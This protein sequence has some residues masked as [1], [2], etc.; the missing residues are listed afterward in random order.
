MVASLIVFVST[1]FAPPALALIDPGQQR[2]FIN[3]LQWYTFKD[4][5]ITNAACNNAGGGGTVNLNIGKDFTLGP[6]NDA[7]GRQVALMKAL[8]R[9]YGLTPTQAAGILGNFMWESGGVNIPPNVNEGPKP[10]PPL[11]KGGYGWA[12]WT[13]SRQRT[14]IRFAT[15]NGYMANSFVDATDA[16][17]YA[18]L[19]NELATG[20]K[21]TIPQLKKTTTTDDAVRSFE[22]TYESAGTPAIVERQTRAKDALAAFGGGGS[23]TTAATAPTTGTGGGG[24]CTVPVGDANCA[25]S[26]GCAQLLIDLKGQG[27]VIFQP[28]G[29]ADL[30]KTAGGKP[31]TNCGGSITLNLTLLRLLIRLANGLQAKSPNLKL[32]IH[33]FV[34]QHEC[35]SGRHPPGR[36]SDV[37]IAG[38]PGDTGLHLDTKADYQLPENKAFAQTVMDNLP[39]P[40]PANNNGGLGQKQFIGQLNNTANKRYFNDP[41]DPNAPGARHFHIDVG[42]LAP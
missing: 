37:N 8:I 19:A 6:I 40:G 21:S 4:Q 27:K 38:V 11:F 17:D 33:N 35:D 12:Q 22:S 9:D 1:I 24:D 13:G 36:A 41:D 32:E 5:L 18:Y 20:Y 28:G 23:S 25:T 3:D 14:F 31:I 39:T 29:E 42:D 16:A 7:K 30:T 10:G 26:Q 2:I 15:D 34:S